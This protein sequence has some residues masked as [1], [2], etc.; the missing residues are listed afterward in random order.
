MGSDCV[1]PD[2]CLSFYC[3]NMMYPEAV[4]SEG[5]ARRRMSQNIRK[6]KDF[7]YSEK[8]LTAIHKIN[9]LGE[10]LQWD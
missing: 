10:V 1:I 7:Y 3:V 9:H 2:H 4:V 5:T 8:L 6:T